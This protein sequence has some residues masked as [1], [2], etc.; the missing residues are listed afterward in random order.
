MF[1]EPVAA[2]QYFRFVPDVANLATSAK[3]CVQ[4][5]AKFK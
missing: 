3:L 1:R 2:V 5:Q 4:I